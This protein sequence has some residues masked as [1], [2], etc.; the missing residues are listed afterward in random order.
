[1]KNPKKSAASAA[2][3]RKTPAR[4]SGPGRPRKA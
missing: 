1:M 2:A 4:M 3:I